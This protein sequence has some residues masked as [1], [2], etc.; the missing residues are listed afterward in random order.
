MARPETLVR[1]KLT[2]DPDGG[3]YAPEE[4]A[5]DAAD[6]VDAAPSQGPTR[7]GRGGGL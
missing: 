6:H 3:A 1:P 5:P 2:A 4:P 7:G